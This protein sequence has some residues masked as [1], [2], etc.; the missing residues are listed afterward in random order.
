MLDARY[1]MVDG[2]SWGL[3]LNAGREEATMLPKISKILFTTDLS[4]QTRK[5]FDYALSLAV[6]Y[7]ARLVILY[8][9]EEL[10]AAM[11]ANLKGFIGDERWEQMRQAHA[12]EA[13]QILIGKRREGA[14]IR[15]ALGEMFAAAQQDLKGVGVKADEIVVT[16]GAAVDCILQEAETRQCDLIVMGYHPRGRLEEAVIGSVSRSVLRR[17]K[18]PVLLVRL[19]EQAG[20]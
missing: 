10:P 19:P 15:D 6:Q 7:D 20:E 5:A 18:A 8:V 9:M 3:F 16:H 1:A 13:Q 2:R 11:S 17:A 12:Q 4:K 14:M